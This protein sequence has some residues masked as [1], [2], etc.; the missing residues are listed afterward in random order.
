M[1]NRIIENIKEHPVFFIAYSIF[2]IALLVILF[3]YSKTESLIIVNHSWSSFQDVFFKYCTY[4]GDG[5]F[6][7][8]TVLFLFLC[9]IKYGILAAICFSVTAIITQFFKK[10]IY[11]DVMR[12]SIDL[13]NDF[14]NNLLHKVDGV[15]LLKG[16]SFPSGH[17]T[18]V[19]SICCL[20]VL[21][22]PKNK[23]EAFL[24]SIAS[25]TAYSRVY[26]SQ[27]YFE[28]IF[29]GSL[30]GCLGTLVLFSILQKI[31]WGSWSEISLLKLKR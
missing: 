22:F 12:P 10:V 11:S 2:L 4:L 19:F 1:L 3:N 30:I 16:N 25:L 6:A 18:S 7:L 8:I 9:R 29:V 20:I 21:L 31:K 13:Y 28:D 26:L 15:E 5:I 24:I 14:Q 17:T 27:H 23:M